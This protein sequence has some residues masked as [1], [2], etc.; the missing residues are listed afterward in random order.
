MVDIV[1]TENDLSPK[2]QK[3]AKIIFFSN[4][5]PPTV[6]SNRDIAWTNSSGRTDGQTD[7]RT[8]RRTQ[9]VSISPAP[10]RE[11]GNNK[12]EKKTDTIHTI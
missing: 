5:H 7:R 1:F 3:I 12:T 6:N 11:A 9:C 4:F 2:L 8:D 10:A